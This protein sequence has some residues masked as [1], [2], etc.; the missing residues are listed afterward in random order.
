MNNAFWNNPIVHGVITVIL[1]I[2]PVIIAQGGSWQALTLGGILTAAYQAL[3]NNQNGLTV[4]G[5]V[6]S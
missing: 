5:S 2:L 1:F 4:A 3:K 6:R